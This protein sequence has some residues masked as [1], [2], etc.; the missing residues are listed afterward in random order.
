M[1]PSLRHAGFAAVFVVWATLLA[2]VARTGFDL[3]G[4]HPL[5]YLGT[6]PRSAVLFTAGLAVSALLLIGF[7]HYLRARFVVSAGFSLAMLAGLA[8]QLVAAFVPIGGDPDLHRVHTISALA[9]GASLPLLMWRFAA[10][11][12]PGPWRRLSYAWFWAEVAACAVGLY[13]SARSIAPVAEIVPGAVFHAWVVTVTL[14]ASTAVE[15]SASRAHRVLCPLP[16]CARAQ[17]GRH[18]GFKLAMVSGSDC[19]A[20]PARSHARP[21]R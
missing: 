20:E 18:R 8:G 15:K 1:R 4:E 9:L 2:A 5:S 3:F 10:G 6:E 21:A 17:T 16:A 11:Q 14:V 13:L 12:P 7:H 19:G